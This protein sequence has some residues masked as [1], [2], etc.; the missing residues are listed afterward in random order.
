MFL[1]RHIGKKGRALSSHPDAPQ[2]LEDSLACPQTATKAATAL[3]DVYS[4]L[5][6]AAPQG[7][8]FLKRWA[9]VL[10]RPELRH[11]EAACDALESAVVG[12]EAAAP[13]WEDIQGVHAPSWKKK[14]GVLRHPGQAV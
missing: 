11:I 2:E 10:L 7:G 1:L 14:P 12:P 6:G 4:A 8:Y 3:A 5:H 9:R 13:A